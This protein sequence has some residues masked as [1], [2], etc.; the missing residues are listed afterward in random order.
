MNTS[1]PLEISCRA[2][3]EKLDAGE[4]LLLLDCRERSEF[5]LVSIAGTLLLPMSEMMARAAEL[6]AHRERPIVVLCHVGGRSAQVAAWLR[7]R[8]FPQAQSMAGGID[9][10]AVEIDPSLARY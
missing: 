6:D 10:W 4:D 5:E 7:E 8:N 1:L 9:A 3:K 2:V